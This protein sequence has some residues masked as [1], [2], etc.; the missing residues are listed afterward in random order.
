MVTDPATV[1]YYATT[2]SEHQEAAVA[3]PLE[4]ARTGAVHGREESVNVPSCIFSV[5]RMCVHASTQ[6]PLP[7]ADAYVKQNGRRIPKELISFEFPG[8]PNYIVTV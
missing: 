1:A 8:D 3:P 4:L 7:I 5:H 6:K 2:W